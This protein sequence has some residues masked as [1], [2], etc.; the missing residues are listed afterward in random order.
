MKRKTGFLT[1]QRKRATS[2][3]VQDLIEFERV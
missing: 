3:Q 2:E 1:G